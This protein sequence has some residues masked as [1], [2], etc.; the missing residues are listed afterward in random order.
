MNCG[1]KVTLKP[2][3]SRTA[4]MR[5]QASLYMRPVNFGH[6]KC[7]PPRKASMVPPTMM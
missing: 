6:Q 5:P 4:E 2:T 3:K 1:K 7:S